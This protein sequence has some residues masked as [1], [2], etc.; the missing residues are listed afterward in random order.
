MSVETQP[1]SSTSSIP[2]M[3]KFDEAK[4]KIVKLVAVMNE[5][6]QCAMNNRNLRYANI[7]VEAERKAKKLAADEMYIPQHIIDTNIRRE[8]A[9]YVSYVT[10]ARRAMILHNMEDSTADSSMLEGDITNKFRYDGW[11]LPLFRWIDG[12]E[13]NGYGILELVMDA[14]QPGH[15][16]FQD[17]AY[18]DFGYSLDSR[19][20]QSCEMVVRRYYFTKTQLLGMA[21]PDTW[22]FSLEQTKKVIYVQDTGV[23]D[24][25]EQSL[26]KIEKVMFRR[27]GIVYVGWSCQLKCDGWLRDP[28]PLYLGRQ[29]MDPVTGT[30][31]KAFETAY[32]YW[33]ASYNISENTV[34][35]QSKGRAYLDQDCQEAV[36]S[37]MSSYVT[38]HRR[39]AGLYFSKD[40]ENDPNSDVMEQTN[41]FFRQGALINGKV[42]QFQ[43][44]PPDSSMLQATQGLAG[45]NMQESSQINFTAMNRQDSKKTA[46][47]IQAAQAES[48]LL[49][50]IQLALFSTTMKAICTTFFEIVRSRVLGGLIKISNPQTMMLYVGNYQVRPSG[51]VD[52]IEKQEKILRM[53]QSWGIVSQTPI[54]GVFLQKLLTLMFPE[55]APMYMQGLQQ[56]GQAKGAL[57]ACMQ[58][59]QALVE[60][61]GQL[62]TPHAQ[63][64]LPQIKQILLQATSVLN[65]KVGQQIQK[66]QQSE[67][68][69][70]VMDEGDPRRQQKQLE[71]QGNG[72][73]AM[74]Q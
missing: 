58:I 48:Q 32:P 43:L 54:A 53:Q 3:M 66:R 34:M 41:V 57:A 38:A 36:T 2:N 35:R 10:G 15:L 37:L 31:V 63:Q 1:T 30:W 25:K 6:E 59:I 67:Q 64:Y 69:N 13:Q 24:Y 56:D 70:Q 62:L 73:L 33:C 23:N 27:G 8:Q 68:L 20:I 72:Q 51:D 16:K 39:A 55:D 44:A 22:K 21:R 7:D 61:P 5:Q 45:M 29:T 14:T 52:V 65:P 11:Q 46:S 28:K 49:S 40:S 26:Y 17:V 42:K 9:R 60:E 47:E 71:Q 19:D 50:S 4:D 74:Q 18:G 12:M